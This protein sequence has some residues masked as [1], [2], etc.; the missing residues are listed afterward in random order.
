MSGPPPE[1]IGTWVHSYEEDTEDVAVYRPAS[2]PLPPARGRR[3]L[4]F[5]ADGTF[6]E[7]PLGRGDA[8]ATRT[9]RW[10]SAA[11][12]G[13]RLSLILPGAERQLEVLHVD[14]EVLKVRK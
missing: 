10:K 5:A 2:R 6:T 4:E 13:S 1:L 8:P 3:G 11:P 7:R 12:D 9:G 14:D